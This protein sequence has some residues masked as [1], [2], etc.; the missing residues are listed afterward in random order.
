MEITRRKMLGVSGLVILATG[1]AA[2]GNS[3]PLADPNKKKPMADDKNRPLVIGSSKYYSSGIIA[4]IF[5]QVLE[6]KGIAVDRQF[7]IG[8]RA[9]FLKEFEDGKID[10]MP[11]YAGNLLQYYKADDPAV[12]TEE[13]KAAL[14]GALPK[15]IRVLDLA[16]AT[17][18]DSYCVTDMFSINN[19]IGSLEDLAKLG[20]PIR[21]AG[22]S[23]LA[24]RPYGP[25][26]LKEKYGLDVELVPVEDG[27]GPLTVKALKD[28]TVDIANIFSA[29]PQID[30]E[31]LVPL[32]DPKHLI[33]TQNIT[34]IASDRVPAE[35]GEAVNMVLAK[36]DQAAIL[37]IN[38]KSV[39]DQQAAEQIAADWIANNL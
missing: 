22:N 1:L 5:A 9:V 4:E 23:E 34:A 8:A 18:Q 7:N 30:K 26:G 31:G 16:E 33:V 2:C 12:S 36:L 27:G 17:D 3:N 24:D 28:G 11:E 19:G 37:G 39:I 38:S 15:G 25:K 13:I 10:L 29:D 32:M 35:V 14:P 21:L 6:S 20:R